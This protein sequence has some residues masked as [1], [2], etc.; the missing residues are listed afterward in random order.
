MLHGVGRD[1]IDHA[2]E[3]AT[4][5]PAGR[6][7]DI[8][9]FEEIAALLRSASG[10]YCSALSSAICSMRWAIKASMAHWCTIGFRR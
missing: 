2:A 4:A 10:P 9:R 5:L 1:R 8:G 6:T 3:L 7:F